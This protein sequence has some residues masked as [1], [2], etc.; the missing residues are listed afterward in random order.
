MF[1]T[2][3]RLGN[4]I[5]RIKETLGS[6]GSSGVSSVDESIRHSEGKPNQH[7][8]VM[9]LAE[10]VEKKQTNDAQPVTSNTT[11]NWRRIDFPWS[12]EIKKAMKQ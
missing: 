11:D 8:N 12:E 5:T 1:E 10:K 4:E 2:R 3:I 7:R 6:L 9:T